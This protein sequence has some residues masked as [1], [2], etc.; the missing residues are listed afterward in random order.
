MSQFAEIMAIGL[1]SIVVDSG[2]LGYQQLG[3]TTG[4]PADKRSC[5]WANWL[6]NNAQI[7]ASIETIGTGFSMQ[8]NERCEVAITGAASEVKLN[9]KH[10]DAWQNYELQA[11]DVI[12][13]SKANNGLRSYIAINRGFDVPKVFDSCT[14]VT[15]D[16]L[17]GLHKDGQ[18]LK[19]TDRLALFADNNEQ[20]KFIHR[21]S[22]TRAPTSAGVTS[23]N[24]LV[25][26]LVEGY[27]IAEFQPTAIKQ[28]YLNEYVVSSDTSRM[29][30]KLKG[31]AIQAPRKAMLSEGI[32]RGAVQIPPQGLPIIM[33]N[34]RQTLGGYFKL[35]SVLSIDCDRL[36]QAAPECQVS[37][38][39]IDIQTAHNLVMLDNIKH[40]N[41]RCKIQQN[42]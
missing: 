14:T 42:N 1:Q 35:G 11:G 7:E 17:G 3:I 21:Q 38:L 16:G 2:R 23:T 19:K 24:Q 34:D 15:R 28:F 39:P 40:A 27:Q 41:L 8:V 31:K 20:P 12:T 9:G 6:C 29:A 13:I 32:T 36:A 5:L 30:A 25:L 18:P 4:G 37:F 22:P 10:F 26:R 33:L